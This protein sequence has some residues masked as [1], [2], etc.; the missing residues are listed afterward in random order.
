MVLATYIIPDDHCGDRAY[1]HELLTILSIHTLQRAMCLF[2][3]HIYLYHNPLAL[4][5][6]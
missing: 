1:T 3:L 2:V 6:G 4:S 5:G